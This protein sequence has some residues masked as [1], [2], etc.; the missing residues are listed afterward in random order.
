MI[1]LCYVH[2]TDRDNILS[3][4]L[5]QHVSFLENRLLQYKHIFGPVPSRR[6]GISL[7]VDLVPPKTCSLDCVYCECGS[8]THLTVKRKEYV[9]TQEVLD[10]IRHCLE[11][12]PALDYV[13]FSGSGEPT[14]HSGLGRIAAYIKQNHPDYNLALLTNGALFY[15]EDVREDAAMTDLV[16]ASID[17]GSQEKFQQVNRPHPRLTVPAMVDGLEAFRNAY[18]GQLWVEV[19]LAQGINDGDKELELIRGAI[20]RIKPD[21][22]QINTLDRPGTEDWV[23]PA[24]PETLERAR[25]MLGGEIIAKAAAASKEA[26][27]IYNQEEQILATIRRRPCTVQDLAQALGMHEAQV[28]KHLAGLEQAGKV[29]LQ[30]QTR[31][32]FYRAVQG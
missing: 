31:G 18:S 28:R 17:A 23:N 5:F 24:S 22:V 10:E 25:E 32:M 15:L 11:Q 14:L 7:G 20:D 4:D 1:P 30:P 21:K 9:P 8:T 3:A 19:F 2:K 26:K 16:I 13:T 12:A 27:A 29:V 6:L